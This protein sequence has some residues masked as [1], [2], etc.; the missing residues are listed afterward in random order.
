MSNCSN[1]TRGVLCLIGAFCLNLFLGCIYLWGNIS[2]YIT[3]YLNKHNEGGMSLNDTF[4]VY[5][6][7]VCS[8][9]GFIWTGPFL[10]NYFNPQLII[11]TAGFLGLLGLF[12]SSY[13]TDLT[14][15]FD[16]IWC[17]ISICYWMHVSGIADLWLGIF[18]SKKRNGE[19]NYLWWLWPWIFWF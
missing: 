12:L 15:F 6:V 8:L 9:A 14:A 3:S 4:V 17:L 10:L 5:P 16:F 19:W 7:L 11:S 18:S 13:T 2:I 1:Q